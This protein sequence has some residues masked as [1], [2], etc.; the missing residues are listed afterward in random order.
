MKILIAL[1][2]HSFALNYAYRDYWHISQKGYSHCDFCQKDLKWW[3][4]IPIISY[5]ILFGRCYYCNTSIPF[6]WFISEFYSLLAAILWQSSSLP[7]WIYLPLSF[8]FIQIV[9]E[10]SYSQHMTTKK[11]IL[12]TILILFFFFSKYNLGQWLIAFLFIIWAQFANYSFIGSA[13]IW[14]IGIFLLV[15][16]FSFIHLWLGFSSSLALLFALRYHL[17]KIAF[18]PWLILT[19]WLLLIISY[20]C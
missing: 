4:K 19:A 7:Y 6:F 12:I 16:P 3:M 18:G 5:V 11:L 13:D 1:L 8:L 20:Q 10:D 14:L 15:L 17:Q 2:W 9:L